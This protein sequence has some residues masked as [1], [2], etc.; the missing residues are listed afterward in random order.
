M[1]AINAVVVMRQLSENSRPYVSYIQTIEPSDGV[2]EGCQ[3]SF[4]REK[5]EAHIAELKTQFP[6]FKQA[7]W[8]TQY[9]R[10]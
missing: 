2:E 5:A 4:L 9:V 7:L 6:V 3:V 8:Y 1:E 10:V